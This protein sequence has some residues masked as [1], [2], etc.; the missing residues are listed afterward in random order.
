MTIRNISGTGPISVPSHERHFYA[1]T[2]AFGRFGM[3]AFEPEEMETAHWHGHVE[4][5]FLTGGRMTYEIDGESIEVPEAQLVLFW[6]GIPHQLTNVTATGNGPVR[7]VNLYIPVDVFLFFPHIAPLQIAL[8]GG[9]LIGL[10]GSLCDQFKIDQWYRDYQ[11]GDLERLEVLKMELNALLRRVLLDKPIYLRSPLTDAGDARATNSVHIKHV[12]EM[13]RFILENLT[14]PITNADVAAAIGL[15]QNYASSLFT[16]TMRLP[17]KRFVIRMR[18]L[19]ARAMLIESPMAISTVA[20]GAGFASISQF[21]EHFKSGYG[22]SPHAMR[23]KY[24]QR[25]IVRV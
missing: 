15:H 6:A 13:V 14:E 7:L 24:M 23:Q 18:L 25:R 20:S 4:A 11:L 16:R 9:A 22:I 8:L 12:V 10:P 2:R 5:N 17:I 21:Y 1:I 19:R 3:R